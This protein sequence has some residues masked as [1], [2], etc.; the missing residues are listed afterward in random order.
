MKN[1][2]NKQANTRPRQDSVGQGRNRPIL[3]WVLAVV[4]TLSAAGYQRLVGPTRPIRGKVQI[5]DHQ[6]SYKLKKSHAGESDHT[7]S[8]KCSEMS[9]S[10]TLIYKRYPTDDVLTKTPMIWADGALTGQ[11]PR[12][13]QGGKVA[14]RVY[15]YSSSGS[16]TTT[17]SLDELFSAPDLPEAESG[18]CAL[19]PADK[20]TTVRFR[21]SV[22]PLV[23]IPHIIFIFIG[24]LW[25]NRAGLE[26]W[27]A[28]GNPIKHGLIAFIFL[29]LGG[30]I[31]GPAVQW[32]S[33]GEA[34]TGFPVGY[35]LTDNKTLIAVL[36]WVAALIVSR[37][38]PERARQSILGAAF[39]TLI[40]FSIPH[41]V[42]GTELDYSALPQQPAITDR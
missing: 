26:F 33:F 21:G 27:R 28:D 18:Y 42:L 30:L 40:I 41:S 7:V 38:S 13:P 31:F 9:C 39:V 37:R 6:I 19:L 23:M 2:S 10:G 4:I 36:A 25:S 14:Y 24:M 1:W 12:Q 5:T 35:D 15:L 20:P 8:I 11:L 16:I 3:V 32:Y 29:I 22:P 34:W 17:S